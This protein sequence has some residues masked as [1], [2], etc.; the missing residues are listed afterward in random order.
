MI[1]DILSLIEWRLSVE[2]IEKCGLYYPNRIALIYLEA[3]EDVMGRN[4]LV[5]ALRIA[6]LEELYR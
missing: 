1:S 6:G 5:A 3:M 4:G 2:K